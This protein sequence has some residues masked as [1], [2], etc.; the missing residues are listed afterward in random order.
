MYSLA[1]Q[2]QR[3]NKLLLFNLPLDVL[4]ILKVILDKVEH[5]I[6][7][8]QDQG[9]SYLPKSKAEAADNVDTR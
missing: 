6:I 9:Q 5:D 1:E 4:K 8:Y 3:N 7:N 2:K